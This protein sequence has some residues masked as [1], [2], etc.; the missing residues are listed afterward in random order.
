MLVRVP[1]NYHIGSLVGA[2]RRVLIIEV[3]G[4]HP[5]GNNPMAKRCAVLNISPGPSQPYA[6]D[7]IW[8]RAGCSPLRRVQ[9]E[10]LSTIPRILCLSHCLQAGGHLA[11]A[12]RT[13]GYGTTGYPP[14]R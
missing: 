14:T 1:H 5:G 4:F 12:G 13:A 8:R 7:T 2:R 9:D 3:S 10:E 6:Y 11:A